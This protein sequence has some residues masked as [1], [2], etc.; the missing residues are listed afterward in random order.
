M[1]KTKKIVAIVPIKTNSKR[2][3]NKNFKKILG[4]PLYKITLEKL[5]KCNFDKIY[6]DTDSEEI[7]KFS[8]KNGFHFIR[9]K[10]YLSKDN[11]N[12]NHLINY[13]RSIID[14]DIYF[15]ILITSPLVKIST[16]NNCIKILKNSKK[17]DSIFT[18]KSLKTFFWFKNKPINYKT[19]ELPRSQDLDPLIIE[20]TFLYGIKKLALDKFKSRIGKKPY[21]Y[22]VD[23]FE[24]IDLN[25]K[26]DFEYLN[27]LI[28]YSF[29]NK[30]NFRAKL[31]K[32]LNITK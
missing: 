28:K 14:A 6:V 9:R 5:K 1:S 24:T 12:G 22:E 29:L 15:Q 32:Y 26:K 8:V 23:D 7:R 4:I 16:I 19:S 3:K 21:L 11:A 2:V 17:N 27:Y 25:N 20:T 30:K 10:S 18:I 31:K 13:H